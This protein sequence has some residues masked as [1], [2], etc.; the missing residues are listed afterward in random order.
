M[1]KKI[2]L[3]SAISLFCLNTSSIK[4]SAG[5]HATPTPEEI[6]KW[7]EPKNI[8]DPKFHREGIHF[9][10]DGKDHHYYPQ[11]KKNGV[12]TYSHYN[13]PLPANP[14]SKEELLKMQGES[15][16]YKEAPEN[17]TDPKFHSEGIHFRSDGKDHHYYPYSKKNGVWVYSH[18]NPPLPA[19]PP[20]EEELL[21]MQAEHNLNPNETQK[22]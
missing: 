5:P 9:H 17:I 15:A 3:I 10:S 4:A 19:N 1:S 21:K 22:H 16:A 18:Y 13:P 6:A 20:S 11:T 8:S 2:L 7:H 12:W 14:S